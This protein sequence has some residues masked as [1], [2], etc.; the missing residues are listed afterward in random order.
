[1][2]RILG[3]VLSVGLAASMNTSTVAP[4]LYLATGECSL[5]ELIQFTLAVFGVNLVAGGILVFGPGQ[6]LL[7][8][9][10]RPSATTRY[11]LE[12][13]AGAVMLAAGVVVWRRR[14]RLRRKELP[15]APKSQRGSA[16]LGATIT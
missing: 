13:I 12:L 9:V 5:R 6:A 2:L 16:V 3:L 1:M 4:A 14:E 7:A 10:P 15:A 8:L 11:I